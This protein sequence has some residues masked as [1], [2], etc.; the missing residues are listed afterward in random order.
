MSYADLLRLAGD[1]CEEAVETAYRRW[2]QQ[3]REM[4]RYLTGLKL[5]NRRDAGGE[6]FNVPVRMVDGLPAQLQSLEVETP[7]SEEESAI[8]QIGVWGRD[9]SA[10]Q[11]VTERLWPLVLGLQSIRGWE[12]RAKDYRNVIERAE[13]MLKELL[14]Y[15][16]KAE[17]LKKISAIQQDILGIYLSDRFGERIEIYWLVIGATARLL[18]VEVEGLTI[19]VLAH[20][21]AHAYTHLGVD[22]DGKRWDP[23][24]WNCDRGIGE[25]I[26]QYYTQKTVEELTRRGYRSPEIAYKRLLSCQSGPYK[27]HCK[28]IDDFDY[29]TEV[30]RTGLLA[31]RTWQGQV[32]LNAFNECLAGFAQHLRRESRKKGTPNG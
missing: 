23:G 9:L 5:G 22:I 17:L 13:A 32:N 10:L 26:A 12:G 16:Q 8:E 14:A 29:T 24:F 19:T 4:I 27:V 25:G 30:L 18:G 21:M 31:L 2:R 11:T 6:Q 28:W 7:L 3:I 1:G 20:E 15:A